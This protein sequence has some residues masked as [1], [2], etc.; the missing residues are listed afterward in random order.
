MSQPLT[1]GL[2]L[3]GVVGLMVYAQIILKVRSNSVANHERHQDAISYLWSMFTDLWVWSALLS[4][5]AVTVCWMLLLRRLDLAYAYPFVA[6]TFVAV[7]I[8]GH[9]VLGE[10]LPLS[11][12]FGIGF[13]FF[14][15]LLAARAV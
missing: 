14:G 10:A 7:P 12:I 1:T 8:A 13:I 15:V 5:V 4:A 3:L 2:L 11:R 9:F 6:L